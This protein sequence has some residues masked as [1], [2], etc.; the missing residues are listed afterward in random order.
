MENG[1]VVVFE[2]NNFNPEFWNNLPEKDRIRYYGVLGYGSDKN[3]QKIR[4]VSWC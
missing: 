2:P 1:T 3:Q 4:F